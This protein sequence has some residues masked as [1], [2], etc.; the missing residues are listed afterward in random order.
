MLINA[1]C[2]YYDDLE[3]DG[4][5]IPK[6]YSKQDVHYLICL[7]PDGT[8][9]SIDDWQLSDNVVLKKDKIS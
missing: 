4:K 6:G 3:R 2:D 7:K 8:I 9:N 1:L 5:L